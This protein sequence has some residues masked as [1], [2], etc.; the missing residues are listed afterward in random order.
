MGSGQSFQNFVQSTIGH[1]SKA[2]LCIRAVESLGPI[3]VFDPKKDL[4]TPPKEVKDAIEDIKKVEDKLMEKAKDAL[5]GKAVIRWDEMGFVENNG[6]IA[7]GVQ[8]NPTSLHLD[9]TAGRQMKY[10]GEA[11]NTQLQQYDAPASTT[12]S[13]E[14]LFDDCNRMDAFMM[15]ENPVTNLSIS[16]VYNFTTDIVRNAMGNKYS[17]QQQMEGLLSLLTIEQARHVI[18]FWA[19]MVFRG[20]V[21]NVTTNYTMFN[22][23][24]YPIRGKLG[25]QIR[26]GDGTKEAGGPD[27]TYAFNEDYWKD[28][29]DQTF[30]EP[31]MAD[32]IMGGIGKGTNNSL[33]NLKL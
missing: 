30:K 32:K 8:Y 11:G 4:K 5:N 27:K 33:L 18:F 16:N 9:T 6:Y 1:A 3:K 31:G 25:I 28:A 7:L 14:L 19:G 13:F 21:T 20:E 10:S 29:F 22:K 24:G 17:V 23:K 12:L 2:V 15:S 26:Q